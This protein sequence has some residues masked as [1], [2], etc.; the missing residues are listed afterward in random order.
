MYV[1]YC[2]TVK[3]AQSREI[4][5]STKELKCLNLQL[6]LQ[7]DNN[8]GKSVFVLTLIIIILLGK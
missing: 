6:N 7:F 1:C 5:A 3:M 8:T 2:G 4:F